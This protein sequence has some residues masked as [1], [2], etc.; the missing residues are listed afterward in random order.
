MGI[1]QEKDFK[2][3]YGKAR[4]VLELEENKFYL[5]LLEECYSNEK[6]FTFIKLSNELLKV[7]PTKCFLLLYQDK[8]KQKENGDIKNQAIKQAIGSYWGYI[9]TNILNM[10]RTKKARVGILG[11]STATVFEK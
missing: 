11:V 1:L 7:P 2:R 3:N 9:F 5:N 6:Y 8:I 4:F 10:K